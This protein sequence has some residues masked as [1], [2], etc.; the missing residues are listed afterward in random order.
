VC[1]SV[2]DTGFVWVNVPSQN[3]FNIPSYCLLDCVNGLAC[4]NI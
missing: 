1:A 4:I 2:C 3:R